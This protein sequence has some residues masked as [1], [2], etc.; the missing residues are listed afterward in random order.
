MPAGTIKRFANGKGNADKQAMIAAV[1][2]RGF[3][4][5]VRSQ[6][7]DSAGLPDHLH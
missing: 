5:A 6:A 3:E 1:R 2:E 4:P 7:A